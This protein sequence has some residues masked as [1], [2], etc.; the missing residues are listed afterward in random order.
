MIKKEDKKVAK[1]NPDYA[2]LE[3]FLAD[4]KNDLSKLSKGDVVEGTIMDIRPGSIIVDVGYKSE[5]IVAG[6]ELKSEIVDITKL[7]VGDKLLVY[8]VKPEDEEGRLVLSIRRTQQA[9]IWLSL[10]K[11]KDSNEI[12]EVTVIE[13]NNGGL[14]CELGGGIR[15]FIPTSQLD[16][17]RVYSSG[18]REVGQDVSN[19]VNKKLASLVGETIKTRII[20][21]DKEKNRIILSEKMLTQTR[22]ADQREK[23]L[24]SLQE[25]AILKG[26]VSG[27][28]PYGIF[29]NAQGLEGLVHLSELSWDKI[30]NVEEIYKVGDK[31]DVMVIGVTDGGKRVAYSVKRLQE[32]PWMSAISKYKV[33]DVVTGEVQRVA[34]YGAFVRIGKGLNGL[35]HISEISDKLVKDPRDFVKEGDKVEVK[36]LSISSTERHLGL[37]LKWHEKGEPK[38]KKVEKKVEEKPKKETSPEELAKAVDEAIDKEV[39]A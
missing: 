2:K 21:L 9:G 38:A 1:N 17:V 25:G 5:G 30:D 39:G 11:A 4:K 35:V 14:I 8:V 32:D 20:E 27:V 18:S 33:G 24:K 36:I 19:K 15:G 22:D 3:S 16:P 26:E 23:T 13:S 31:V 6:K 28:T 7:K 10:I 37:S 12:V 34:D 29:V